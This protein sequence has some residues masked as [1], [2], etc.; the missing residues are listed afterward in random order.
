VLAA[1]AASMLAIAG[2]ET[3]VHAYVSA[4]LGKPSSVAEPVNVA[5]AGN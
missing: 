5:G 4:A 2:P 3:W 1:A